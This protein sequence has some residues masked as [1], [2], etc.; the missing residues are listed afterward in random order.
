MMKKKKKEGR[1][2]G[3]R[4]EKREGEE[5]VE[6]V[7]FFFGLNFFPITYIKSIVY[8]TFEIF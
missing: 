4:G 7:D 1:R 6:R 8:Y 2:R 5:K 3:G